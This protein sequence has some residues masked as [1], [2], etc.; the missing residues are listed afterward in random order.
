MR[1]AINHIKDVPSIIDKDLKSIDT[2]TFGEQKVKLI[3]VLK[4]PKCD[5][6][7]KFK[8]TN[9]FCN[10]LVMIYRIPLELSELLIDSVHDIVYRGVDLPISIRLR[11]MKFQNEKIPFKTSVKLFNNGVRRVL[12]H[13]PYFQILKY[14]LKNSLVSEIMTGLILDEFEVLFTHAN[15]THYVKMEIADIFLLN[16]REERGHQMLAVLRGFRVLKVNDIKTVYDDSQNVHDEKVNKS[17]L[18]A[19]CKLIEM[20]GKTEIDEIKV[21][22]ELIEISSVSEGAVTKVLERIE[23]DT[24]RF[25][26]EKNQFNLYIVF[27]NLW[28]YINMH[29]HTK[30]LKIRLLEE[31]ISMSRYCSTGHLSRFINVIQGFTEDPDLCITISDF[32]QIKSVIS[33]VLQK[34][35]SV[36]PEKVLDSMIEEDQTI[37]GEFIIIKMNEKIPKLVEEYGDE[38]NEKIYEHI[39]DAVITYTRYRLL[40][41]QNK[42]LTMI[43]EDIIEPVKEPVQQ[44]SCVEEDIIEQEPVKEL[45]QRSSC[46]VV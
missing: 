3:R 28:K 24:A 25:M 7:T 20:Y 38:K 30:E 9:F 39:L 14:I 8:I 4:D 10:K 18:R 2:L 11:Y 42:K 35:L 40:K 1:R 45:V 34:I 17:V 32:A 27:A 13:I 23:I 12:D 31:I 15:I 33:N 36:A 29:E 16:K 6:I 46:V 37:F 19:A 5:F 21:K 22:N 41:I 44:S 26:H 43:V